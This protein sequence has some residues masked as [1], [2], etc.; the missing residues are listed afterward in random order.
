MQNPPATPSGGVVYPPIPC[1][2]TRLTDAVFAVMPP[3]R[4]SLRRALFSTNATH[5]DSFAQL[6]GH[7]VSGQTF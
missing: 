5:F 2:P 3:R 4:L 1:G 7:V 6:Q